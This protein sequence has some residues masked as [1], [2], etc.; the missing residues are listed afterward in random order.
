MPGNPRKYA[1]RIKHWVLG[2]LL[3]YMSGVEIKNPEMEDFLVYADIYDLNDMKEFVH[4]LKEDLEEVVEASKYNL[5]YR[6][7][8]FVV[9]GIREIVDVYLEDEIKDEHRRLE[10]KEFFDREMRSFLSRMRDIL[11]W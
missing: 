8:E 6:T 9:D 1:K 11:E 10:M 5:P 2:D 3:H 4:R 7:L